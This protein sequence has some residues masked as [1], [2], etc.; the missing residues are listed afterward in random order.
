MEK[1]TSAKK[2]ALPKDIK[3]GK[4]KEDHDDDEDEYQ[5][6][7]ARS[8]SEAHC[9]ISTKFNSKSKEVAT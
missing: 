9:V 6:N 4:L 1:P 7:L 8:A 2:F 3:E 5:V